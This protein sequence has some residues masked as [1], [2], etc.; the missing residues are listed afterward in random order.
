MLSS[1]SCRL[2]SS[3]YPKLISHFPLPGVPGSSVS[4]GGP[5]CAKD[6]D[7]GSKP[8]TTAIAETNATTA[9]LSLRIFTISIGAV[10]NAST[11]GNAD[12]IQAAV[13]FGGQP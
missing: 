2:R 6:D 3:R 10:T 13:T 7:T 5:P 9:H 12:R 1:R 4:I 11:P 8:G